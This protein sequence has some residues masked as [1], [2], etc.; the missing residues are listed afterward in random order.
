MMVRRM[1]Q[2]LWKGGLLL[3]QAAAEQPGGVLWPQREMTLSAWQPR[4]LTAGQGCCS[5]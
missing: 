2:E 5:S 3:G 4:E 1:G